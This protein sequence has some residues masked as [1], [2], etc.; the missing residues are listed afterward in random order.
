M[1]TFLG[2]KLKSLGFQ[3]K[4]EE[5]HRAWVNQSMP[6]LSEKAV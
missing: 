6:D 5:A 2:K 4:V 1:L 3:D